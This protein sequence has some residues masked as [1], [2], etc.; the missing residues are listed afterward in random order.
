MYANHVVRP[1]PY[2]IQIIHVSKDH[3]FLSQGRNRV[4]ISCPCRR[5]NRVSENCV[6]SSDNIFVSCKP[7]RA[8]C[9]VNHAVSTECG[10]VSR[11]LPIVPST[12]DLR[13]VPCK[14]RQLLHVFFTYIFICIIYIYIHIYIY[15]LSTCLA[16]QPCRVS[17]VN[18]YSPCKACHVSRVS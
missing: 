5:P 11:V 17:R 10:R 9:R 6:C 1:S 18:C 14:P 15:S 8:K 2:V 7:C 12:R 3:S 13:A 4:N 16:L